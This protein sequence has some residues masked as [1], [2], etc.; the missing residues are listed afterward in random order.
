M[1]LK[2][3]MWSLLM[4]VINAIFV[5]NNG[6]GAQQPEWVSGVITNMNGTNC[7]ILGQPYTET[8]LNGLA[9][10]L[11]YSDLSA[12]LTGDSTYVSVLMTVPG[13]NCNPDSSVGFVPSLVLPPGASLN[14]TAQTPVK[15]FFKINNQAFTQFTGTQIGVLSTQGTGLRVGPICPDGQGGGYGTPFQIGPGGTY[16]GIAL[17]LQYLPRTSWLEI[18]V[19]VRFSKELKGAAGPNGGDKVQFI[20]DTAGLSPD[21]AVAETWINVPYRALIDPPSSLNVTS[22]GALLSTTLNAYGEGGQYSVEYGTTASLGQTSPA[23]AYSSGITTGQ[24]QVSLSGLNPAT[25]YYFRFKYVTAKGTFYSSTANFTTGA[26]QNFALSVTKNGTGSGSVSSNPAGIVCG[27]TCSA[28]FTS[29]ANVALTATPASGSSFTGWGGACS[30]TGACSVTM[31]ANQSVTATFNTTPPPPQI[32]SVSFEVTGLPSGSSATLGIAGPNGYS[33]SRTITTG[34]GQSLSDVEAGAYTVTAPNVTVGTSTYAPD[35]ATQT[36]TVPAG[37]NATFRVVYAASTVPTFDLTITKAGTGTGTVSSTPAG[38]NCGATCT[39]SFNQN[40]SVTLTAT[41]A[42]G[43]SFA[44]WGGAC[45]GSTTTCTITMSAAKSVTATFTTVPT[46]GTKFALT[47]TKS[48]TG[49]GGITSNPGG[50]NCGAT[51][52]ANFAQGNTVSLTATPDAASNFAGWSGA[53]SGTGACSVTM[54]AAKSVTATFTASGVTP[55]PPP[56]GATAAA[57]KASNT[58]ATANANKGASNVPALGVNLG[59]GSSAGTLQSVT[60]SAAGSGNDQLDITSAK[61]YLDANN[62]G[63]VDAGETALAQGVFNANDGTTTLTLTTPK[64]L[65]ASSN[66]RLL[67]TLDF[68]SSIAGMPLKAALG[69]AALALLL[70]WRS[71]KAFA[72]IALAGLAVTLN[73][74]GNTVTPVGVIRTYQVTMTAMN[75]KDSS[76]ASIPVS[77]LPIS[78]T[79]ISVTK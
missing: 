2:R 45:S 63:L 19:P 16:G 56:A 49:T 14:I 62:N 3:A 35:A 11:H 32:G 30:G 64:A 24:I 1:N 75:L 40:A 27:A 44:S 20:F 78:G 9:S 76:N 15:C 52:S 31:S 57:S 22:S 41:P 67:V 43:S 34:T 59:L 47:V 25:V 77:G 23:N 17:G 13:L 70:G 36:K 4:L 18:Q 46:G 28:N 7:S 29:G 68:N 42:A 79:T 74:C 54:S 66:S 61:L 21:P 60:V 71:R 73:A 33:D 50:I 39:A 53:C 58:P 51:C 10:Y 8:M 26:A 37:G 69:S 12:P 65:A 5:L 38:I 48:G 72:V 55:P 6:A